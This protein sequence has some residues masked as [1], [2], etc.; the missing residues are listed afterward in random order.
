MKPS[1]LHKQLIFIILGLLLV[2]A[3]IRF[4]FPPYFNIGKVPAEGS[5]S[6]T[7]IFNAFIKDPIDAQSR[8]AG[9]AIMVE[10]RITGIDGNMIL[11]GKGMEVVRIKLMRS[12]RYQVPKFEHGNKIL[13]KGI[14]R[15]IDL[16]EVLVTHSLIISVRE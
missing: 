11:M 14:C 8:Y 15:G 7:E 10:G 9:K 5:F 13:I 1:Y 2:G 6:D 12:W 3:T 16:T 4:V